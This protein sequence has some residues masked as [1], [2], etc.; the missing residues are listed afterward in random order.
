[1]TSI[2]KS[3]KICAFAFESESKLST[4]QKTRETVTNYANISLAF[5]RIMLF[6][7]LWPQYKLPVDKNQGQK[8]D[9]NYI[10]QGCKS[11]AVDREIQKVTA[12]SNSKMQFHGDD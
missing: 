10:L 3:R 4:S 9:D 7:G 6:H 5:I 8:W 11:T 12:A 1:M 2:N